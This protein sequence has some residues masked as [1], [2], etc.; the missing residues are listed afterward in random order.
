MM[1]SV[2]GGGFP[3]S[4]GDKYDVDRLFGSEEI[5]SSIGSG[6][7]I[8]S[9]EGD[10]YEARVSVEGFLE[11]LQESRIYRED[12]HLLG[13]RYYATVRLEVDGGEEAY[14]KLSAIGDRLGDSRFDGDFSLGSE[15]FYRRLEN[16][17]AVT[18]ILP[19]FP[20]RDGPGVITLQYN[21]ED[22]VD[23]DAFK[24]KDAVLDSFGH[25]LGGTAALQGITAGSILLLG[26]PSPVLWAA[27]GLTGVGGLVTSLHRSGLEKVAERRKEEYRTLE[28]LEDDTVFEQITERNSLSQRAEEE[29]LPLHPLPKGENRRLDELEDKDLDELHEGVMSLQFHDFKHLEGVTATISTGDYHTAVEFVQ[30]VQ[31]D[32]AVADVEEP[33]LYTSPKAF[34][35]MFEASSRRQQEDLVQEVIEADS[36]RE[37]E[38]FLEEQYG[39]LLKQ[40]GDRQLV[41]GDQEG[42]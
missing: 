3:R 39:S 11:S 36:S 28:S 7:R 23:L 40:V 25:H 37:V 17:D 4:L 1:V 20:R 34:Q 6:V 31:G 38:L 30:T 16:K 2:T 10:I 22:R 14:E 15:T 41:D 33:S 19:C 35:E 9:N 12:D 29:L 18:T 26:L 5:E 32:P 21:A 13:R 42:Y 27:V 8:Y 24:D